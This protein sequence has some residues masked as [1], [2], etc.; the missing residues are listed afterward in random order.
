MPP[1]EPA[2]SFKADS[3][4]PE[5]CILERGKAMLK[6]RTVIPVTACTVVIAGFALATNSYDGTY[7]GERSPINGNTSFCAG[8][9]S[10]T[11]IIIGRT[12]KFTNSEWRDIPMRFTPRPNGAFGGS[13]EDPSGHVVNVSGQATGTAI[14]A[15]V[16]NYGTG[17]G[18]RWH[19]E[20]V[21]G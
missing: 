14:D 18:H 6:W 16:L 5:I 20:K 4:K 9:E 15:D 8:Q 7:A 17:C 1:G 2:L 21:P 12:L 11:V 13:L 10:V 19:L 3:T